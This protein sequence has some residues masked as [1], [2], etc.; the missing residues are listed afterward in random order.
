MS[1]DDVLRAS[2]GELFDNFRSALIAVLPFADR[3][4]MNYQ[5]E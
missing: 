2:I 5:D 3:A 1:E 4:K